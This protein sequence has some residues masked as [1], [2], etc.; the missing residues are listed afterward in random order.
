MN[1]KKHSLNEL[2]R[3]AIELSMLYGLTI[4]H[5]QFD[6]DPL[7][8]E[9]EEPMKEALEELDERLKSIPDEYFTLEAVDNAQAKCINHYISK[10]L[11]NKD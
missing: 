1:S 5:Q 9:W 6:V 3:Y 8:K 2:N 7:G 11:K 4:S 10:N